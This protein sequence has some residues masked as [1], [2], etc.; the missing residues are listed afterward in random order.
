MKRLQWIGIFM[1]ITAAAAVLY[2]QNP[3]SI[4]QLGTG[5]T[6]T[7]TVPVSGTVTAN[8][9]GSPWQ[10]QSNSA[11]IATQTTAAAILA[12]QP[13]L[14]TAG[15]A[16]TD[17]IT[18]QGIASMTKLLV[19]P[20]ANSAVNV[21]QINGVTPLMGN[22]ATGTG[23]IRVSIANDSTGVVQP[24]NTANTT[25]WLVTPTPG[26]TGG[27]SAFNAT[28]AD[29]ATACTNS[30]QAVK[31]S[32]GTFG[33]Y[34]IDNPNTSDEWLHVYDV[35]AASVTVGTTNPKLTFRLPGASANSVAANVEITLGVNFGTAIAIACTSTAGGT[36]A[37]ANA[38]EAMVYYK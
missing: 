33:G 36:G 38:L 8:Q 19:T 34:Y 29:G 30:A 20:D 25:P 27:W 32:A 24:G 37:P 28:A 1:T 6:V 22:G 15:T 23:A 11:N 16:S 12:K 7:T 5:T 26:T 17:V 10:V 9:G 21:A 31:A 18:I 2:A 13:A 3:V 4:Q 14:G 35:A